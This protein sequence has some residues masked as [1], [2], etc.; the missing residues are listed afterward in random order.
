MRVPF[1]FLSFSFLFLSRE[2]VAQ[3]GGDETS[4]DG[5]ERWRDQRRGGSGGGG[6]GEGGPAVMARAAAA[7]TKARAAA[8]AAGE[9]GGAAAM[10]TAR[11]AAVAA[12]EGLRLSDLKA[13]ECPQPQ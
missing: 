2:R 9:G 13:G 6:D 12:G 3:D 10:T 1:F 8:V 5:G 7:M 11:A 4:G